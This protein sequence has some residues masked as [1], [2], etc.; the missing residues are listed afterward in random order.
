[1]I[2]AITLS[3]GQLASAQIR[4]SGEARECKDGDSFNNPARCGDK[5]P[6]PILPETREI[7]W[8]IGSF[9]LLALLM[10]VAL[11]PRLQRSMDAR[12]ARI[13]GDLD[14]ADQVTASVAGEQ[15]S[16]AERIAAAHSEAASILDAARAKAEGVRSERVA[17]LNAELGQLRTAATAEVD[18]AKAT[19]HAS[20]A[21]S[22]AQLAVR[23]AS[24]VVAKPL[25]VAANRG[26]VDQFLNGAN[27]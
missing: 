8:G 5:E 4:A 27:A 3:G 2:A 7:I 9:V 20:L 23:A 13:Q 26:V 25:D 15:R 21:D 24:K 11:Y 18:G 6:N 12:A 16:Y 17:A 10:R 14:S 1:V 22:V 19:A